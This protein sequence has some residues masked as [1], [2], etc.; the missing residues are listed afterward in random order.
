MKVILTSY[1]I[2]YIKIKYSYITKNT[3]TTSQGGIIFMNLMVN[4]NSQE[5]SSCIFWV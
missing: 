1:S 5:I 3:Q 2:Q 4:D